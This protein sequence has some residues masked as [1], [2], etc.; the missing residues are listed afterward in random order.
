MEVVVRGDGRGTR[1]LGDGSCS[2]VV[3]VRVE[4]L[5]ASRSCRSKQ[6]E[7]K[8]ARVNSDG[9]RTLDSSRRTWRSRV[10]GVQRATLWCIG[11][12]VGSITKVLP[13]C[14]CHSHMNMSMVKDTDK[15][16][17]GLGMEENDG[18]GEIP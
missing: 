1:D 13:G 4:V 9:S 16:G 14:G 6:S 8:G 18:V 10:L 11:A 7:T 2:R 17:G 3:D 12:A 5:G 15:A